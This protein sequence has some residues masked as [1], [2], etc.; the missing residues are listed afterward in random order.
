MRDWSTRAA[1][2]GSRDRLR[3]YDERFGGEE[4][5]ALDAARA[6]ADHAFTHWGEKASAPVTGER[7]SEYRRRLLETVKQHAPNY[8]TKD[9]RHTP[10]L[11]LDVVEERVFHDAAEAAKD[12]TNIPPN[13]LRAVSERDEAGRLVTRFYGD[14]LA[15]M[16]PMM[17]GA[18]VG[19]LNC[20]LADTAQ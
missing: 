16:A 11:M 6:R 4:L 17:S 2:D 15:W 3:T 9:F 12:P 14:P 7:L 13:T 20:A 5:A 1:I 18:T 8:R 10:S 19:K